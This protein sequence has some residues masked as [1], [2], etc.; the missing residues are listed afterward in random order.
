MTLGVLQEASASRLPTVDSMT[1]GEMPE[2]P[3]GAVLK[4]AVRKYRGFESLSLRCARSG[5]CSWT[6]GS[7]AGIAEGEV[8]ER[9]KVIAC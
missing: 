1:T 2:R 7:L 9:P 5:E 8:T 3:K 4:T 6:A